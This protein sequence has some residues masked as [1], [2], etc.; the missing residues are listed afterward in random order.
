VSLRT[1]T[2]YKANEP[3]KVA[4]HT[5]ARG[6]GSGVNGEVAQL[7]FAFLSGEIPGAQADREVSRGHSTAEVKAGRGTGGWPGTVSSSA[8]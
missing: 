7:Q 6:L 3:G 8:P 2:T 4:Q 1:E 5:D